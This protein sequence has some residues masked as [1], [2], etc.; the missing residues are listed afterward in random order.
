MLP[1]SNV[2]TLG[3]SEMRHALLQ[4][5]ERQQIDPVTVLIGTHNRT[6]DD[7]PFLRLCGH[8]AGYVGYEGPG[9]LFDVTGH[10][11]AESAA[12]AE[13]S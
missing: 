12:K 3:R 1:L 9:G 6:S 7:D 8:P 11:I 13:A 4:L 10:A 5:L 2:S